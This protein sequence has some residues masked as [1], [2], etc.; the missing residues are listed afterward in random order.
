MELE[1]TIF[2][3]V[4]QDAKIIVSWLFFAFSKALSTAVRRV[5]EVVPFL[6]KMARPMDTVKTT[7]VL[8]AEWK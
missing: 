2:P 3:Q 4:D 6:G 8:G 1:L 5:F 7:E